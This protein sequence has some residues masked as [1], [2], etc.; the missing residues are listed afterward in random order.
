MLLTTFLTILTDIMCLTSPFVS[1]RKITTPDDFI[2]D[3]HKLLTQSTI[4]NGYYMSSS[5][6]I[7]YPHPTDKTK[8]ITIMFKNKYGNRV[9][10]NGKHAIVQD[11][12]YIDDD[13]VKARISMIEDFIL[14]YPDLD[15]YIKDFIIS[16]INNIKIEYY[17]TI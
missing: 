9:F 12:G 1:I 3:F 14:D 5:I 17:K 13:F 4:Y 7:V 6:D 11:F 10:V 8:D 15:D 16:E 2:F